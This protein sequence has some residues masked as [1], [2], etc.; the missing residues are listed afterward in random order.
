MRAI[1]TES[2]EFLLLE[3]S[4]QLSLELQRNISHLIEKKSAFVGE[5][6]AA[7][8]LGDR[9]SESA[10]FVSKQLALQKPQGNRS[11]IQFDERASLANA[12]VVD[13]SGDKFLSGSGFS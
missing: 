7:S 4:Q 6:E 5:L 11:A 10:P 2:F 13:R 9:S 1:A 8:L 3:H 12:Q